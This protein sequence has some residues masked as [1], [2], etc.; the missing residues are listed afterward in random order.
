[1]NYKI[2]VNRI[3]KENS[4]IKGFA[5]VVFGENFKITNIAILDG[6]NGLYVQMPRYRTNEIDENGKNIYRDFCNPITK[7]FREELYGNIVKTYESTE[8]DEMYVGYNQG[9]VPDK[10]EYEVNVVTFEKD[11]SSIKGL[12]RVFFNSEFIVN[13]V[14]ILISKDTEFVSMP[15]YRTNQMDKDGRTIYQD[16]CYPVTKEFREELY[17][18]I[19]SKYK[20]TKNKN[21]VEKESETKKTDD[22]PKSNKKAGSKSTKKTKKDEGKEDLTDTPLKR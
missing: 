8:F 12:A 6:K 14:S 21:I 20:E 4:N 10:L 5:N 11:G 17:G 22:S 15:S 9:E 13:N 16:V 7:E 19:L 2:K 1:M 18:N 3:Q